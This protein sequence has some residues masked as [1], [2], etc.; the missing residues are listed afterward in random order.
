MDKKEL[1]ELILSGPHYTQNQVTSAIL[2]NS[3]DK[4]RDPRTFY[5]ANAELVRVFPLV[6]DGLVMTDIKYERPVNIK[7]FRHIDLEDIPPILAYYT[8]V[9]ESHTEKGHS[10]HSF[11]VH[12]IDHLK[13]LLES[14]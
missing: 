5:K 13:S 14:E 7:R 2:I 4:D 11:D 3:E 1:T 8:I 10:L 9:Q 12:I 6:E